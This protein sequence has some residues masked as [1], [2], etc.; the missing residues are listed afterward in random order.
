MELLHRW[1]GAT[2]PNWP[3]QALGTLVLLA[4]L[5]FRMSRWDDTRFRFLY[6]FAS[7]LL[8]VVLFNHQAE[9]A[10]RT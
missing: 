3:V 7:V 8:F 5:G 2:F 9:R 4:P 10:R 6:L 1:T